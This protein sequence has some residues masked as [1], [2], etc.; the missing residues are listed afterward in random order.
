M[1]RHTLIAYSE[2]G[3]LYVTYSAFLFVLWPAGE[4]DPGSARAPFAVGVAVPDIG[5]A[6]PTKAW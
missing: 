4:A 2:L 1:C 3:I 6:E 5:D